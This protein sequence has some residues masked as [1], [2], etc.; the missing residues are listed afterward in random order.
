MH[1]A[2]ITTYPPS[3]GSLGEYGFH[4]VKA[5]S[6]KREVTRLSVLADIIEGNHN[7][8]EN[9]HRVW[10]FNDPRNSLH[11]DRALDELDPDAV[12]F[13]FQFASFGDKRVPGALGLLAPYL[14]HRKRPT[15][16]LLHNIFETVDL[17]SAGFSVNPLVDITTRI[18]GKMLTRLLLKSDLLALTIPRYVDILRERYRASNVFLA[19]HGTFDVPP[20]IAPLPETPTV[21]AFGKFG[22]YK[23]LEDLLEAHARLL[24][25]DPK[26][27]LVVAGSDSPNA[28]GYLGD[29]QRRYKD[30]PNVIYTGYIPEEDL[31]RTFQECTV[32]AFPY[33]ST[34][35]SSGVLHQVGQ[36][37][38]AAVMPRS[39]RR[40]PSKILHP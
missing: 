17:K 29:I 35:G 13:S 4:L 23:K 28:P 34:T 33:Q 39:R 25:R 27:K 5:F 22:T 19:P 24:E 14:S 8:P 37:G 21:L 3:S 1:L 32:A 26:I 10:R 38:R 16:A 20:N 18:A 7:E 9:I 40:L 30:L 6:A 11:I 2:V 36:Y 31:P 15:V 12:L